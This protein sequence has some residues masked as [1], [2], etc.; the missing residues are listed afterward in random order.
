M[1]VRQQLANMLIIINNMQVNYTLVLVTRHA[2]KK[3]ERT[4]H[5]FVANG[6]CHAIKENDQWISSE[7]SGS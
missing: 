4:R 5:R 7:N 3:G 6:C 1:H 2:R